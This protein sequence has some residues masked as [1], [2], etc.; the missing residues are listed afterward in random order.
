LSGVGGL[1][2]RN[3]LRTEDAARILVRRFPDVEIPDMWV[4]LGDM[5]QFKKEKRICAAVATVELARSLV[6]KVKLSL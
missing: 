2:A 3:A 5:R 4:R 1:N 6:I